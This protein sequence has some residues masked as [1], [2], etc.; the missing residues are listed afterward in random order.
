[1]AS[2]T[3]QNTKNATYGRVFCVC[4]LPTCRLCPIRRHQP[5][6]AHPTHPPPAKSNPLIPNTRMCPC[7]YRLVF[8]SP[9]LVRASFSTTLR[10][11]DVANAPAPT[12]T[13]GHVL[14]VWD[15]ANTPDMKTR[16]QCRVF[17]SGVSL[18]SSYYPLPPFPLP[19]HEE[20]DHVVAFF[21]SGISLHPSHHPEMK[22]TTSW[23]RSSCLGCPY[24]FYCPDAKN[25]TTGSHSSCLGC[26]STF[27]STL[28]HPNTKNATT[29]SRPSCLGYSHLIQ[30]RRM[31][32]SVAFSVSGLSPFNPDTKMR[33]IF[34]SIPPY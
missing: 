6:L 25:V 11:R 30:T 18:H 14:H 16:P 4:V 28:Y 1:M 34:V 21:M 3:H 19:R 12:D 22:N 15:V 33:R 5:P 9:S 2:L 8:P 24:T 23:S 27:P 7:G 20:R 17:V 29:G 32:P 10:V 31:R 13:H 26:P